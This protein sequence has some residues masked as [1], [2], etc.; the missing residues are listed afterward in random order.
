VGISPAESARG[1]QRLLVPTRAGTV[2]LTCDKKKYNTCLVFYVS[3]IKV[4]ENWTYQHQN[5]TV[6]QTK[7]TD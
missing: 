2:D 5:K 1:A 4:A 7:G 6:K 3:M